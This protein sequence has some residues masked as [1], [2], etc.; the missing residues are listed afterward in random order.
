MPSA[1]L[2]ATALN[3]V[4]SVPVVP[5]VGAQPDSANAAAATVAAILTLSETFTALPF[6]CF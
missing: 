6:L 4:A 3:E 1:L 2:F 5:V